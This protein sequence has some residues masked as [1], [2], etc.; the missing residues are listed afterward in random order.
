MARKI[1]IVLWL[2]VFVFG[3]L[4][5]WYNRS[6]NEGTAETQNSTGNAGHTDDDGRVFADVAWKHMPS[7]KR[8]EL[9]DQQDQKF[10]SKQLTGKP[11]AISF[12]FANCPSI[13]RRLNGKVQGLVEEFEEDDLSFLSITCDPKRDTPEV[14]GR[15]AESFEADIAKWKFLTGQFYK[16]QEVARQ[17]DV[18]LELNSHTDDIFLVDKWG[19]YRDRFKW[20]DPNELERFSK[21]AKELLEETEPP[22]DSVVSTR[23]ALAGVHHGKRKKHWLDEF[24]MTDQNGEEFYS[25]DLTGEVWI[26]SMFFTTCTQVCKKQNEYIRGLQDRLGDRPV[27]LVSISTK[28]STDTPE[29]LATYRNDLGVEKDNWHFLTGDLTYTRRISEEFFG[30]P[31]SKNAHHTTRLFVVDRWGNLRDSFDWQ[32]AG[33]EANMI[34]LI[35]RLLEETNPNEQF[36]EQSE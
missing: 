4:L 1:S 3:G 2:A 17:F 15:Y 25:R 22:L 11:Y 28:P 10:N 16:I 26:G 6:A 27:N 18:V 33:T 34:E 14:L 7:I 23:N 20:H 31:M 13:C 29:V 5:F 21:V 8:F 19:R 30:V 24:F 12:F 36:E 35:D 32:E 9:N